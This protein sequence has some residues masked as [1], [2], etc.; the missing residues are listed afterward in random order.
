MH[1]RN[2]ATLYLTTPQAGRRE[3]ERVRVRVRAK[4]HEI[5]NRV[6][7]TETIKQPESSV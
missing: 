3:K 5:I 7:T 1:E 6:N 2:P 4:D